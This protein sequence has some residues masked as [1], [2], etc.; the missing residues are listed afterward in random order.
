MR[1]SVLKILAPYAT[2]IRLSDFTWL[3]EGAPEINLY[4]NVILDALKEAGIPPF[5]NTPDTL[6][7]LL[8]P[9]MTNADSARAI[10]ISKEAI[11]SYVGIAKAAGLEVYTI[12]NEKLNR[13]IPNEYVFVHPGQL[14]KA[15]NSNMPL[16]Q[17]ASVYG[18]KSSNFTRV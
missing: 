4:I 15:L 9:V 7:R 8:V 5:A 13:R 6:S 1:T 10:S 3:S 12:D 18:L 16:A 14:P 2:R 17:L 11:S